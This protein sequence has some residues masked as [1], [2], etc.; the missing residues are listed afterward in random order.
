M[1]KLRVGVIGA[2]MA[3]E[4]LHYPAYMNLT[5]TYEIVAVCDPD[6]DKLSKWQVSLGLSSHDLY[7]DW[8]AIVARDDV[9]VYDIMVPIELNYA[10]TE[11]VA[12]RLS[13]KRKAIICEKPLAG[14][15]KEALSAREL[16]QRYQIPILIAENYRYNEETNIIRQLVA[17][18]RVGNVVYFL[19]NRV[20]DFPQ[21]MW[22]DAFP[23]R[24]WRQYPEYP[25]GA[26]T[27]SAVHDLAAIRHI[28][29]AVDRLQAFG[30]PQDEEF[31]PYSA[32]VVN[33]LFSSG[34]VGQFSFFC[35]GKEAQR[36]A[37]GLRIFG[38]SGMIYLE[39]RDAGVIHIA[40]NDGRIEGIP[41]EPQKG[42]YNEL[43]NLANAMA[44][45]EP[46][47][48]PPEMEYGDLKTVR[49]ILR[50]IQEQKIV[51]VDKTPDYTPD[52][53]QTGVH[54]PFMH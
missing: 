19:Y 25:G 15:F 31:S 28:F 54:V 32:I 6:R 5:D 24:D 3:F 39:S 8:E 49:D 34:V 14:S 37:V 29:G 40:M 4:R 7:T 36:P 9:D 53:S 17:D 1:P 48:V 22:K 23:A 42:Y 2:G 30:H 12:K 18:N 11:A 33:M 41:F 47:S 35:A 51:T 38:D 13:G 16:A 44:G 20:M 10:V 21:E 52:Y 50:S 26:I 46:I 43:L 45:R 27:D